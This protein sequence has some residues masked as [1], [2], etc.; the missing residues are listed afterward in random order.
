MTAFNLFTM[1][2]NVSH[3]MRELEEAGMHLEVGG[4]F[5]AFR[6]LRNTQ[7]DRSAVFPMFD[8]ASSYVD[9]SNALWIC[10]FDDDNELV[11]TQAIRMLDLGD[12]TLAE[13]LRDHRHKYISP[14]STVD[15]D[16][17]FFSALPSLDQ[18]TGRVGYHGEFWV[19]GSMVGRR[20]QGLT[21]VMSRIALEIAGRLWSPDYLFGFVPAPLAS[22]G[23][24]VRYGYTR[25]EYGAWY[26]PQQEV[27]SEEMFVWMSRQD[28]ETVLDAPPRT[29]SDDVV[30]P[31]REKL[32]RPV[33]MVA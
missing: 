25:C 6:R 31:G 28:L 8:V 24:T 18:I 20:N 22:R 10:A 26:G 7:K 14:G 33:D 19:R 29:L 21:A 30:S 4:D 3:L 17:T 11:H 2:S 13:H 5:A 1:I 16:R 23:V 12:R 32:V 15:P 9:A 27:T